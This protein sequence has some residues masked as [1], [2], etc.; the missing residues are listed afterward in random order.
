MTDV[1]AALSALLRF[2]TS[3]TAEGDAVGEAAIC[4]HLEQQ[5]RAAGYEPIRLARADAP[6]RANLVLRVRG[7]D[8]TLP[9]LAVHA[10]LDTVPAEPEQWSVDP[11][12]GLVGDGWIWGRGA[13]DMKDMVASVLV[14]L[15]E[16][17]AT[18]TRPRRDIVVAFVADEETGGAYGA[19]W[20]VDEHPELFAGVTACIGESG[21][22]AV[23]AERADGTPVT[24]YPVATAERGSLHTRLVAHG[25]SGHASRP[26][27]DSALVRL[28]DCLHRIAHQDWPVFLAPAV[29]AQ[30]E[31]TA[32][33]LGIPVDLSTDAGVEAA[34]EALGELA[35]PARWT[36]RASS[37]PTI[38]QAGYSVNVVPGRATAAIDVRCPPG[39]EDR[40]E[41]E[42]RELIGDD[43]EATCTWSKPVSAP[44]D[45]EIVTAMEAAVHAHDPGGFV[46]PYCMGGG[47]DAKA[48]SRIGIAGY[49][50]A[51]LGLDPEGRR[52][53]GMHGVDERVPV[54]SLVSGQRILQTFLE[55]V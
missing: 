8:P 17:A 32:T 55:N 53:T 41:A 19:E 9:G 43:I 49:G 3:N 26:V 1:V 15:L 27:P 24:L 6:H 14:T 25:R 7:E 45:S 11:W 4:D 13:T 2:D 40:L 46:F 22:E 42:L 29:R 33:A 10:H 39:Y 23:R 12:G 37:T 21:A 52:G 36:I 31:G 16:W 54:A 5:L 34:V 20:L 51:P 38:V 30:L 18:G 44:I 50:F 28:I 47:T 35:V 48:F